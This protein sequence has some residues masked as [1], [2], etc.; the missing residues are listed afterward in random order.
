MMLAIAHGT[1]LEGG[2]AQS[3]LSLVVGLFIIVDMALQI[4][5]MHYIMKLMSL[6]PPSIWWLI[7][8]SAAFQFAAFLVRGALYAATREIQELIDAREH[9][10]RMA[11]IHAKEAHLAK[12]REQYAE[13]KLQVVR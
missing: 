11:E 2:N 13:R 3:F 6:T 9:D 7:A 12:R 8:I 1:A 5:A 10:A 4:H